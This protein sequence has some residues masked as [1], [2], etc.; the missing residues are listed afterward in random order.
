[1]ER[2]WIPHKA[3][4][5]GLRDSSFAMIYRIFN[6]SCTYSSSVW[7]CVLTHVL[8]MYLLCE[9]ANL[10]SAY[11]GSPKQHRC[12][13]KKHLT[14]FNAKDSISFWQLYHVV[15]EDAVPIMAGIFCSALLLAGV[16]V[17]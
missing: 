13:K 8:Q 17:C 5:Y 9:L 14:H 7:F 15:S 16:V 3:V 4:Q 11:S 10:T 12:K 6:S 2:Y 1:M